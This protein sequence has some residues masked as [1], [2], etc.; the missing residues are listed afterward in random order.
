MFNFLRMYGRAVECSRK[1]CG[2]YIHDDEWRTKHFI[3]LFIYLH[4][5]PLNLFVDQRGICLVPSLSCWGRSGRANTTNGSATLL[6]QSPPPLFCPQQRV[7]S[8]RRSPFSRRES[9]LAITVVQG[10]TCN[11]SQ[12]HYH[13]LT[14][15]TNN[16]STTTTTTTTNY[17]YY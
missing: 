9:V 16:T 17:H 12:G 8:V 13:P 3:Y 15:A 14:T 4:V 6:V 2:A 7:F 5:K 1:Q 11:E 10:G